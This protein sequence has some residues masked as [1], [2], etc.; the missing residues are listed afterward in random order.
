[1]LLENIGACS[2]K[3]DVGKVQ[4]NVPGNL[5]LNTPRHNARSIILIIID[6]RGSLHVCDKKALHHK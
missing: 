6:E 4:V 1:M 2:L 3:I 5:I